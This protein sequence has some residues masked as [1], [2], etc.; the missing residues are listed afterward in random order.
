MKIDRESAMKNFAS[1]P[2]RNLLRP[3]ATNGLPRRIYVRCAILRV[4]ADGRQ[5]ERWVLHRAILSE[6][7][8]QIYLLQYL[9]YLP[10]TARKIAGAEE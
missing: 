2:V 8:W 9:P 4:T 6:N 7:R 5:P 3:Y 10:A 1:L